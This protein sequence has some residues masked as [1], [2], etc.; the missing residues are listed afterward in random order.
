MIG[1]LMTFRDGTE[2]DLLAAASWIADRRDCEL[3]AGA[4]VPWPIDAASLPGQV[5]MKAAVCLSLVDGSVLMA[6]G[7]RLHR[8]S[9]RAHLTRVIVRPDARRRGLG[10]VLVGE[11]LARARTAGYLRASLNVN[12]DNPAALALYQALGFR[13]VQRPVGDPPSPRCRYMELALSPDAPHDDED[14]LRHV[15]IGEVERPAIVVV[16]YDPAWPVRFAAHET[17]IRHALGDRARQLEHV[18][19]TAVPGLAAKPIIDVL[20]VVDDS[21]DEGSYLPAL[22]AAGYELRIREPDFHEHRMLRTPA[23][24]MHLHVL[25]TGSPEIERYLLLRDR[26]RGDEADRAL[27][28]RTKRELA[29]HS[30]PTMQHYAEAKGAVIEEIIARARAG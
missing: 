8:S 26:L 13:D 9:G 24:D 19:S 2:T 30:W 20:L 10:R 6:F 18:G 4:G 23:R 14:Y 12:E 29:S 15:T 21:A 1:R 25:S 17:A 16:D 7:Q 11:L 27:Y 28:E 3:W 22:E 5:D